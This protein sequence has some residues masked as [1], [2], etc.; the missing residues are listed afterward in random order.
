MEFKQKFDEWYAIEKA[1]KTKEK[2]E[3]ITY[4]IISLQNIISGEENTKQMNED[5]LYREKLY[6]EAEI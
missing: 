2:K 4:E 3:W 5:I 6:K 1:Q